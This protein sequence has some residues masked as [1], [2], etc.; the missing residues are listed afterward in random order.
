MEKDLVKL[1][2]LLLLNVA[3]ITQLFEKNLNLK[4]VMWLLAVCFRIPKQILILFWLYSK[5][6]KILRIL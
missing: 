5:Y 3:Q 1:W 2:R 4:H 6:Y